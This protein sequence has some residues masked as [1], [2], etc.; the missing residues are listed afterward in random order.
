MRLRYSYTLKRALNPGEDLRS[1][2]NVVEKAKND[3]QKMQ[4][5]KYVEQD[6]GTKPI[7]VQDFLYQR[8][9]I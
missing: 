5:Q 3:A 8:L 7:P 2:M 1:D 9:E 4:K 6:L